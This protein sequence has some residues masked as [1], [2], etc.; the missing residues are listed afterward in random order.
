M[1]GKKIPTEIMLALAIQLPAAERKCIIYSH[2]IFIKPV[3]SKKLVFSME[4]K[5]II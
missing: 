1:S 3:F 5:K 2:H 4:R